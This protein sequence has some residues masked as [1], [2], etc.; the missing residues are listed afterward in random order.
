MGHRHQARRL[1]LSRAKGRREK[2]RKK[3]KK[4]KKKARDSGEG[5]S[6]ERVDTNRR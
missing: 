1:Q 2:R 3:K 6:K 5:S 4:E